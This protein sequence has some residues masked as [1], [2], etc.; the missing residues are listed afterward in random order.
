MNQPL[1]PPPFQMLSRLR[2]WRPASLWPPP[3]CSCLHRLLGVAVTVPWNLLLTDPI[4]RSRRYGV[5]EVKS[6][7]SSTPMREDWHPPK[8]VGGEE[9]GQSQ[10]WE[11]SMHP[12]LRRDGGPLCLSFRHRP[13]HSHHSSWGWCGQDAAA[14]EGRL[15]RLEPALSLLRCSPR[16]KSL[17]LDGPL[18]PHLEIGIGYKRTYFH[19][20]F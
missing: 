19:L 7:L 17:N 13:L 18:F 9:L 20:S 16:A 3:F 2:S 10:G 5:K 12:G 11:C 15:L 14:S 4:I 8:E 1:L 6:T